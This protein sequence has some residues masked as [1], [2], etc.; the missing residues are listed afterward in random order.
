MDIINVINP[1]KNIELKGEIEIMLSQGKELPINK[2]LKQLQWDDI[3]LDKVM[4]ENDVMFLKKKK[5]EV[6][7]YINIFVGN[8]QKFLELF[9]K[10]EYIFINNDDKFIPEINFFLVNENLT[11]KANEI[12]HGSKFKIPGNLSNRMKVLSFNLETDLEINLIYEIINS[13][14][15]RYFLDQNY[16]YIGLGFTEIPENKKFKCVIIIA[17]SLV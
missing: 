1:D 10:D 8:P 7:F 11:S 5:K 12:L 15:Y 13:H 3:F 17:D 4:N 2:I 14:S 9:F 6:L 16:A